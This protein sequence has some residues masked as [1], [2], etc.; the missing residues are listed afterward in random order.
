VCVWSK[1]ESKKVKKKFF[2]FGSRTVGTVTRLPNGGSGILISVGA[3]DFSH[4]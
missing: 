4:L 2:L 3:R 1:Q